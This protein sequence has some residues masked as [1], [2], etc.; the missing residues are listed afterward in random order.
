MGMNFSS[1]FKSRPE[2][3][4]T[5]QLAE[6]NRRAKVYLMMSVPLDPHLSENAD[7]GGG[8]GT[9]IFTRSPE[10]D[11]EYGCCCPGGE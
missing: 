4:H 1:A 8:L 3:G 7:M 2:Q 5:I 9:L 11:L 10:H 6:Q